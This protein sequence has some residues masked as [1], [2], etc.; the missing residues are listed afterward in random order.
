M[1]DNNK[2]INKLCSFSGKASEWFYLLLGM[3]SF[4]AMFEAPSEKQ[5]GLAVIWGASMI[6]ANLRWIARLYF[7]Q[8]D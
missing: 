8:K 6:I 7:S 2:G 4:V 5:S 1:E 3:G